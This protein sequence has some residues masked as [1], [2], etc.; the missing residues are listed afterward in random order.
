MAFAN[1]GNTPAKD[2]EW[3][4]QTIIVQGD[5]MTCKVNDVIVLEYNE[6]PGTQPGKS[7]SRAS[8]VKEPSAPQ[9][10]DPTSV[11][12]YKNIRVKRLGLKARAE[13]LRGFEGRQ[14]FA[15]FPPNG[16]RC[17]AAD[18][19]AAFRDAGAPSHPP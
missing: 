15:A 19:T 6:P 3:W 12:R 5:K 18:W 14:P 7:F 4:T 10:H 11:V 1:S 2:G 8:W 17:K 13:I 16:W 9:A